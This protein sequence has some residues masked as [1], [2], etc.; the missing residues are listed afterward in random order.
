MERLLK[1]EI[2]KLLIPPNWT[3]YVRSILIMAN[4]LLFGG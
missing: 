2:K 1:F 4:Y 3:E